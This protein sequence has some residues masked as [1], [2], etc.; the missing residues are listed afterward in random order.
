MK[1]KWFDRVLLALVL[2]AFIGAAVF[3]IGVTVSVFDVAFADF[4]SMMLQGDMVT[5]VIVAAVCVLMILIAIR[6]MYASVSHKDRTPMPTTVLLKTT[7][8]GSIRIALTAVDTMVQR[9]VR[10]SAAVRDV[11]S[12]VM[13]TE[14][15]AIAI[16]LRV[17]FA[18]DTVLADATA[19]IQNE[20]RE[21]V[22]THA[23]VPVQEVQIF[24]DAVGT[25]QLSR[26]E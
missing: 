15:D 5:M 16:Q 21:Y 20:V 6:V 9:S 23:G 3:M 10:S 7:D 18:P 8:N 26:V 12:R 19:Q 4:S 17:T 13:V 2:I 22:Q 14:H 11:N 25:A 1:M 24:V